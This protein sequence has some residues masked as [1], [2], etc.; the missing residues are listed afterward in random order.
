MN[1]TVR[2]LRLDISNRGKPNAPRHPSS[3][4]SSQRDLNAPVPKELGL[5]SLEGVG[6]GDV[7]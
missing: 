7:R 5:L 2:I 1:T 3:A 4:G 6:G